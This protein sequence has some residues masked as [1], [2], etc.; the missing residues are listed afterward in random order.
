MNILTIHDYTECPALS[1]LEKEF[2]T[3]VDPLYVK[4]YHP[5]Y[6][7]V[8]GNFFYILRYGRYANGHGKYLVLEEDGQYIC[9]AGWNEYDLDPTIALVLTRMYVNKEHRAQYY[10]GKNILPILLNETSNYNRVWITSN[11]HNKSIYRWFSRAADGKNPTL[12]NSW[13]E[14]YK[15][16][17]PIGQR[18]VYYTLQD[19]VELNRIKNDADA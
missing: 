16:F 13:P 2:S 14:I 6:T 9:S 3:I 17:K 4:N 10:V 1:L 12:F 8:P 5:D 7:N 11:Q 15:K 18:E 19:V